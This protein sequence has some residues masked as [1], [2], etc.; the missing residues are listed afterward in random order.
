[1]FPPGQPPQPEFV[2][3]Q[4][5]LVPSQQQVEVPLADASKSVRSPQ[6]KATAGKRKQIKDDG[7][8]ER[9]LLREA[10]D[11]F[12]G[13]VEY[14]SKF[15]RRAIEELNFV[16]NMEH[17]RTE[18]REERKGLPCLSFDKIGPSC[19]QVVN[20]MRQSPPEGRISPVG[21]GATKEEASILQGIN[22]NIDQDSGADTARTTAFEHAVKIGIGWWRE[23]FD[24]ESDDT[25]D[26]DTL[27]GLFLQ[28][29]VSK[30]VPNPFSI[31]CDPAAIEYDRSDMRYLFATEDLDPVAFEEENPD[32]K[33]TLPTGTSSGTTDF[34]DLSDKEKD[35][36]FPGKKSIRVA[37]YWWEERAPKETVLMLSTGRVVRLKDFR[38]DLYPDVYEIGRRDIR[39]RLIKM[40][41]LTGSEILGPITEWKGKWI[42][43]VPVIGRE[44]LVDGR[45]GVRG[46]VR[47]AMEA[48]LAYDYMASK[49]AQAVALAPMS[50]FI[51]AEGQ[52]DNHPEWHEANRKA[53][54][55]LT[56]NILEVGGQLV[57]PPQRANT[58]ANIMAIT[59]ALMHRDQD[60]KN[61]L[62]MWG[63]DLGEPA[64]NQSGR[65]ITAIQR[66]GDNAHFN[67]ADNFARSIRHA[68][69]IR[70]NLMPH[71]YSEERAITIMDPDGKVRS[72]QINKKI[73]EEG[74]S[75]IWKV[76]ADFNPARYDVT[77]GTGTPYPTLHAQQIDSVLQLVQTNPAGGARALDLI[78][79]LLDL[80][81][82]FIERWR[83]GDVAADQDSQGPD[84][85]QVNPQQMRAQ[86]AQ[87]GQTIQMLVQKLTQLSEDLKSQRLKLESQER[88]EA[89]H[90]AT[91]ILTAELGAKSQEGQV[92]AK[93]DHEAIAHR[94]ELVA[95]QPDIAEEAQ[96]TQAPPPGPPQGGPPPGPPQGQMPPQPMAPM[97]PGAP[98][99]A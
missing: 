98:P 46:M 87:Q 29:L 53:H 60:I 20:N 8:I 83:P 92:L 50:S 97:P 43:F 42:P 89:R 16:D 84:G 70:L 37:E 81:Q 48:N 28:K 77:I 44:V 57:P 11:R 62:N 54:D 7:A 17:W 69:R 47:P 75:R 82:E 22:R 21:E 39:R 61:S 71:V 14:E 91:R 31:Y 30:R 72:V 2:P 40:V 88:I 59:Q 26:D 15:R 68:T 10:R 4:A 41:K 74:V 99:E 79:K 23:W 58:E 18:Q 65:A 1:M 56:Y 36:W 3:Q 96:Q 94:I 86:M 73:L 51:A 6:V 27:Q 80:P 25:S 76:G 90:D 93:L 33:T 12:R 24:W 67:Y 63:P 64:G 52:I 45:V 35:D 38:E 9:D 5:N 66:Q 34:T 49:E 78:A 55:V 19:D 13:I 85:Q 95:N 32:A